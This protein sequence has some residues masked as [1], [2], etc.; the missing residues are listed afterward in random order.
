[1]QNATRQHCGWKPGYDVATV[2]RMVSKKK[3]QTHVELVRA[4][5]R[6][7]QAQFQ[8]YEPGAM[9]IEGRMR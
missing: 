6:L 4:W 1:M 3:R 9:S 8:K 7:W 5:G 2:L